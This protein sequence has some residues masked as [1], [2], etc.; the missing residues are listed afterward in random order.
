MIEAGAHRPFSFVFILSAKGETI[1][2]FKTGQR[3]KPV[4]TFKRSS[5]LWRMDGRRVSMKV[6]WAVRRPLKFSR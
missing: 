2:L 5:R 1:G 3:H 6:G 4:F